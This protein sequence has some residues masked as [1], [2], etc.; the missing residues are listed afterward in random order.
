LEVICKN[1]KCQSSGLEQTF[2]D[3][4]TECLRRIP[5]VKGIFF[6]GSMGSGELLW[7]AGK[8]GG[9]LLSDVEIG[10]VT[11]NL[12]IRRKVR[13]IA[14]QLGREFS[15]DVEMF[16][17]TPRRLRLGSPKNLSFREHVP[18]IFM[19]DVM[20]SACWLWRSKDFVTSRFSASDLPA[21]EGVRLILNRLG[22]GAPALIPW[23]FENR[24]LSDWA[25]WRSL[26]KLALAL[27][28]A[29]LLM[30]GRYRA[31]YGR[32][33]EIWSNV[34]TGLP[35]DAHGLEAVNLAYKAR[36][37][38]DVS[39]DAV[40]PAQLRSFAACVLSDLLSCHCGG[41]AAGSDMLISLATWAESCRRH[42][43][44]VRYQAPISRLDRLYDSIFLLPSF[45]RSTVTWTSMKRALFFRLPP[46]VY[47]YGVMATGM[48]NPDPER[49]KEIL[50][51]EI[52][53]ASRD[54]L[55]HS[56]GELT[57]IWWYVFC[58]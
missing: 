1:D 32:R 50:Q 39:F 47:A 57:K 51:D 37:G 5:S 2:V 26:V 20:E 52:L 27:G 9:A 46:Q 54:G 55:R 21:W 16:L 7:E 43:A 17:V 3:Q 31:G 29:I 30:K 42:P 11:T 8:V 28:D 45:Y 34:R 38:K 33:A 44:P 35:Y 56:L 10:I 6:A 25:G 36:G 18:N 48:L 53:T 40:K 13:Q 58:K 41:M 19:Y 4:V 49:G 14:R 15:Y 23:F 22:D 12:A 24:P